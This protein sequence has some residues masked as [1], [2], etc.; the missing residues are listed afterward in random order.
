MILVIVFFIFISCKKDVKKVTI[1]QNSN[2]IIFKNWLKD[3]LRILYT[4]NN[5]DYGREIRVSRDSLS[6]DIIKTFNEKIKLKNINN[7]KGKELIYALDLLKSS[8]NMPTK[9][10]IL[11]LVIVSDYSVPMVQQL[12][13]EYDSEIKTFDII[14]ENEIEKYRFVKGNFI[15]KNIYEYDTNFRQ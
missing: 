12:K 1:Q 9:S 8:N 3:T 14:K 13:Y 6:I 5:L 15:E 4:E 10:F 7:I 2:E 11:K